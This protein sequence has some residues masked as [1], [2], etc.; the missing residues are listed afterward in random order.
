[1]LDKS[2]KLVI[3]A[4]KELPD[5]TYHYMDSYPD[6]FPPQE[7]FFSTIRYLVRKELAEVIR[8]QRGRHIGVRLTH[9]ALHY[10]EF[11]WIEVIRYLLDNW[12]AFISLLIALVALI[13][14]IS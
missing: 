12:I 6:N 2:S 13:L 14:S 7:E 4:L 11:M 1:M 10:K 5:A 3:S 9:E 8:D